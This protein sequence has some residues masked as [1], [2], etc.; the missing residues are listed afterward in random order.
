M[1]RPKNPNTPLVKTSPCVTC[2]VIFDQPNNRRR[3]TCSTAC[4]NALRPRQFGK[5]HDSAW[6]KAKKER[7]IYLRSHYEEP[8]THLLNV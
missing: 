1:G 2:G 5:S 3:K 4:L 6:D 7:A 8:L